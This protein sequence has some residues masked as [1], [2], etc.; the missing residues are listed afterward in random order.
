MDSQLI[1]KTT[2]EFMEFLENEYEE[3]ESAVVK[4]VMV[5]ALVD[6]KIDDETGEPTENGFSVAQYRSSEKTWS[7]KRGLIQAVANSLDVSGSG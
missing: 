2:A 3:D 4:E 1:G 5:I 7:H 6:T